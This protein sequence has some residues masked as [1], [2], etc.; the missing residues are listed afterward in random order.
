MPDFSNLVPLIHYGHAIISSNGPP[1]SKPNCFNR[2]HAYVFPTGC[3]VPIS[4]L[5]TAPESC[6]AGGEG[7]VCG[8]GITIRYCK[9]EMVD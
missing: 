5:D 1:P 8:Q 6:Q 7:N 2:P 3:L 9:G 4:I